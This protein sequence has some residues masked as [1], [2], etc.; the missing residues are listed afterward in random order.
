MKKLV[1][2]VVTVLLLA[3]LGLAIYRS[4]QEQMGG[5][6][7][8]TLRGLSRSEKEDFFRDSEVVQ[9]LHHRGFVV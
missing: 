7:V 2:P 4:A 5:L 6:N 1:G 8:A 9:T 3:G